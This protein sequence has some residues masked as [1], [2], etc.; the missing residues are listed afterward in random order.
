VRDYLDTKGVL[1]LDVGGSP[2]VVRQLPGAVGLKRGE[3]R[4]SKQH[5]SHNA[6]A[7]IQ[8]S[9]LPVQRLASTN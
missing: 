2:G 9:H 6:A 5:E 3:E 8:H 7:Y 4:E 1:E